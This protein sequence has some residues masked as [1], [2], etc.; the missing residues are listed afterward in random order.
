VE[1]LAVLLGGRV[2][3]ERMRQEGIHEAEQG[4]QTGHP[5]HLPPQHDG[6]AGDQLEGAEGDSPG[7]YGRAR[8]EAG[9][10][11]Q[12]LGTEADKDAR[13]QHAR[14]RG[15]EECPTMHNAPF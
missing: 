5:S 15:N 12:A 11:Q 2:R 14:G 3:P 10:N 8:E 7:G 6:Q 13:N 1:Q 9:A 4:Q